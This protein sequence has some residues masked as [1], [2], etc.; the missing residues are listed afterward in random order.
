[1]TISESTRRTIFEIFTEQKIPWHGYL[2]E[3]DF[4][5]RLYDLTTIPSTDRRFPNAD[6]DIR[7]HRLLSR[8]WE[9]DW[10][11]YDERFGFQNGD[12]GLLL[13]FL[14]ETI[15]PTVRP[16]P[17]EARY[18]LQQYN[19]LL[20]PEGYELFEQSQ[21]AGRPIFSY[22]QVAPTG[23]QNI[24]DNQDISQLS[25]ENSEP[26]LRTLARL[27]AREGAAIEVAILANSK[28]YIKEI[29]DPFAL[30]GDSSHGSY[31][32]YLPI[33]SYLYNQVKQYIEEIEQ[34]ILDK[35][36]PLLRTSSKQVDKVIVALALSEEKSKIN[37]QEKAKGWL[38][39]KKT[40]QPSLINADNLIAHDGLFFRSQPTIFLYEALKVF[41]VC[42]A[43]LPV[44][45]KADEGEK[46]ERSEPDFLIIKQGIM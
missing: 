25:G 16:N 22:R 38:S 13:R 24:L 41:K 44:L 17:E 27:F 11:F 2:G 29:S 4:L 36:K 40:T 12:E 20:A 35:I 32:L 18:L 1:M 19:L 46:T 30:K 28:P 23:F 37:W 9:D 33:P 31:T 3:M 26:I 6:E 21:V 39:G 43:P 7:K 45:I 10:I 34:R 5:T 15:H 42:F 8:D 14:C